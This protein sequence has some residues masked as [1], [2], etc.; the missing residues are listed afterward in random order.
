[1][2]STDD[3]KLMASL[4]AKGRREEERL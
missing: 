3:L 2:S 1:M 4:L